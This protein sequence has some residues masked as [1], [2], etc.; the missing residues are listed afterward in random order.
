MSDEHDATNPNHLEIQV[1]TLCGPEGALYVRASDVVQWL[2]HAV[3]HIE[4]DCS[5][6]AEEW[7]PRWLRIVMERFT[8]LDAVLGMEIAEHRL[9]EADRQRAQ[10]DQLFGRLFGGTFGDPPS[11]PV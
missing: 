7:V 3:E 1:A 9:A 4:A 10:Y 5:C 11:P 8:D 6:Q 2:G